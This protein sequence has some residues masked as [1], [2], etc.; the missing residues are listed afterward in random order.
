MKL[1][2][3]KDLLWGTKGSTTFAYCPE[4]RIELDVNTVWGINNQSFARAQQS[5]H[6]GALVC[7][8]DDKLFTVKDNDLSLAVRRFHSTVES[9]HLKDAEIVS[10]D[11]YQIP[12]AKA[13]APNKD[14]TYWIETRIN[15]TKQGKQVVVY[16]GKRGQNDKSQIFVDIENDKITFDQNNIHPNDIFFRLEGQFKSGRK[17]KLEEASDG[18]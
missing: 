3:W 18:E 13:K 10:I 17:V 6:L 7:P 15:D 14:D 4:H 5:K 8:V 9:L 12:I 16:A 11:G 2:L 1:H